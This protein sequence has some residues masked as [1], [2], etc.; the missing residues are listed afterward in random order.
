MKESFYRTAM[1]LGE[2]AEER[3]NRAHVIVFGAGGVGGH[4]V[5]ALVRSGLGNIT[6]IDSALVKASNLNR[7][8]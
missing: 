7:Q 2:E 8:I 5:D 1:L 6:V 3:L 4:C